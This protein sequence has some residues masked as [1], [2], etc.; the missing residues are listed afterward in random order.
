MGVVTGK[1]REAGEQAAR[2]G[3][4]CCLSSLQQRQGRAVTGHALPASA[5]LP[6]TRHL[7]SHAHLQLPTVLASPA[8]S[9]QHFLLLGG[10]GWTGRHGCW[11][12]RALAS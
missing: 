2:H 9:S 4:L 7:P 12:V 6:L 1:R 5:P 3:A 10:T 11:P 8:N